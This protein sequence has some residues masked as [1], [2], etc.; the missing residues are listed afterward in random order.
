MSPVDRRD[1]RP[2]SAHYLE[3]PMS[4]GRRLLSAGAVAAGLALALPAM[5]ASAGPDASGRFGVLVTDVDEVFTEPNFCDIT[6]LTVTVHEVVRG[7]QFFTFRGS[8]SIPY[9]KSNFHER[10][11][12]TEPDGTTVTLTAN[13]V[14]KDQ[15]IVDNGDG[16]FTITAFGTGGF[17]LT[18]P[19]G[20]LRDPGRIVFRFDVLTN[21]TPQNPF[22]DKFVEG[23][24]R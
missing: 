23:S 13:N 24:L 3:D 10:T 9:Y 18:G 20:T 12:F 1:A 17:K 16:T 8:D 7:R 11:T 2:T 21:G 5:P 6:G 15:R 19:T 14:S 4:N 22:D